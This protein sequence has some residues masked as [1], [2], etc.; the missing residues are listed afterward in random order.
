MQAPKAIILG[1][2]RGEWKIDP[3]QPIDSTQI[4]YESVNPMTAPVAEHLEAAVK[5]GRMIFVEGHKTFMV[6]VLQWTEEKSSKDGWQD[7]DLDKFGLVEFDSKNR[8]CR[9]MASMSGSG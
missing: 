9:S 5:W 8:P 4:T 6:P 7:S 1:A 2:L 3:D